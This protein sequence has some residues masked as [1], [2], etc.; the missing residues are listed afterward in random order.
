MFGFYTP[1][2]SSL[3]FK[4]DGAVRSRL[5]IVH[6]LLDSRDLQGILSETAPV[7][8]AGSGVA[9]DGALIERTAD[10]CNKRCGRQTI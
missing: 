2:V 4:G 6:R 10:D 8:W 7:D 5:R 9:T 1:A 3:R